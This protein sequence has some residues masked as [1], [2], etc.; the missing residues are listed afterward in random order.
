MFSKSRS[1]QALTAMPIV[2]QILV[3]AVWCLGLFACLR[4]ARAE[5]LVATGRRLHARGIA[6]H[7]AG[8]RRAEAACEELRKALMRGSS[9]ALWHRPEGAPVPPGADDHYLHVRTT[10]GDMLITEEALAL[11]LDRGRKLLRTPT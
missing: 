11:A 3:A 8:R 4:W 9:V 10:R 1:H 7:A 2:D 5:R 6:F